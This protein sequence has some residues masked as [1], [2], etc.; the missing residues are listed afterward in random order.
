M[1]S[2]HGLVQVPEHFE[3]LGREMVWKLLFHC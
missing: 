2:G 3:S 1:N